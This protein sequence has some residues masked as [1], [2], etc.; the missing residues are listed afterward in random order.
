MIATIYLT[1]N[2]FIAP[3]AYGPLQFRISNF[4]Y[5]LA[6]FNPLYALG[7]GLGAFF[8]NLGSPFG[9]MDFGIMPFVTVLAA[10]LAWSLRRY[11]VIACIA[12]ALVISIGVSVFPLGI[13]GHIPFWLTFPGVLVS[14]ALI[15]V[16]G[17]LALWR[18][19]Y[20]KGLFEGRKS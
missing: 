16:V 5:P 9:L 14:N 3:L 17:W 2:L 1:L 12:Q 10:L 20:G 15:V 13:G 4:I 6:L 18:P 8:T 11:P 7:F 19:Y